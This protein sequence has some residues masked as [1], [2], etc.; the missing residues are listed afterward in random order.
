V[1]APTP[2]TDDLGLTTW[3]GS[4]DLRDV[5][6][7]GVV[8]DTHGDIPNTLKAVRLFEDRRVQLV[9]HCGDIGSPEIPRLFAPWPTHYVLGNVDGSGT[10][11]RSAIEDAGQTLHGRFGTLVAGGRRIA[12]IHSDN[13]E[14][15]HDT[16]DSQDWDLLC[17]GHTHLARCHI[18]VRT[19]V[20]NPG[21]V[22]GGYPP[23]VA[24]VDL[25]SMDVTSIPLLDSPDI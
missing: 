13:I 19:V 9:V 7:L 1:Y 15:F 14:L 25:T 24:L 3:R 21:A 2:G 10:Q 5:R 11:L 20:L 18:V 8:S 17:Y 12:L 22:H 16:I 6:W 23:S 4:M